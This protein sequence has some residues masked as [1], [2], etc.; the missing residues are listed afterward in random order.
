MK[1]ACLQCVITKCFYLHPVMKNNVEVERAIN[2]GKA[3]ISF[4]PSLFV[5]SWIP[6]H[7]EV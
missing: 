1:Y 5:R 2:L 7:N 3:E 4:N 6:D